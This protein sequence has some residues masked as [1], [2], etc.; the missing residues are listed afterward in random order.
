[1]RAFERVRSSWSAHRH[2]LR[3][4]PRGPGKRGHLDEGSIRA[5]CASAFGKEGT[6]KS[7]CGP[8]E[9]WGVLNPT[10]FRGIVSSRPGLSRYGLGGKA[11]EPGTSAGGSAGA[12]RL[13]PDQF[14]I[15]AVLFRLGN[16]LVR[17]FSSSG[18]AGTYTLF[19]E[20][21]P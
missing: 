21:T 14:R 7:S 12:S 11:V 20:G 17:V 9:G 13:V 15:S 6:R 2:L 4:S 18:S 19:A 16:Y 5:N 10:L 1:M 8:Q 3:G